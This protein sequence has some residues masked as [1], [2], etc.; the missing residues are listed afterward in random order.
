[1]ANRPALAQLVNH[2]GMERVGFGMLDAVALEPLLDLGLRE[3]AG[4]GSSYQ[5][6]NRAHR[7]EGV[8]VDIPRAVL[9]ELSRQW[10]EDEAESG[11]VLVSGRRGCRVG[12]GYRG[13]RWC[14][15]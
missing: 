12:R 9:C 15:R 3:R 14:R 7:A 1:M 2:G 10:E 8:E 11:G 13:R 5:L 4:I 6:R